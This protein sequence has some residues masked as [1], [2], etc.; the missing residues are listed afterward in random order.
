VVHRGG[1]VAFASARV[2]NHDGRTVALASG[3]ATIGEVTSKEAPSTVTPSGK[4]SSND[5]APR[6]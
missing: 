3:S 5:A 4:T 1:R 6:H 2:E